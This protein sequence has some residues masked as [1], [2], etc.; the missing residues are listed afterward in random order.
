MDFSGSQ[1]LFDNAL[2]YSMGM[3]STV[4]IVM[5]AD[6]ATGDQAFYGFRNIVGQAYMTFTGGST[7]MTYRGRTDS[8]QVGTVADG[9]T[10]TTWNYWTNQYGDGPYMVLRQN[11]GTTWN[12]NIAF[13][14]TTLN[15]LHLGYAPSPF[16]DFMN[17]KIA[18]FL[19]YNRALTAGEQASVRSYLAAK[20][21][22]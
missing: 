9:A 22:I 21:A 17:G 15:S 13:G 20:W 7:S 1:Y 14:A 12:T 3:T 8:L 19:C 2:I 6:V 10:P 18:E 16:S 11:S 5:R 4:F